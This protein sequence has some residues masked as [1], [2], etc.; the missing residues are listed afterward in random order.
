M[1]SKIS[2]GST[3]FSFFQISYDIPILLGIEEIFAY[4]M[5]TLDDKTDIIFEGTVW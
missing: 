3:A 1:D 2:E 4:N 5:F